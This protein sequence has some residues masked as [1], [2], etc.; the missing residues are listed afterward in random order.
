MSTA[1]DSPTSRMDDQSN[2]SPNISSPAS[3]HSGYKDVVAALIACIGALSLGL[4]LGY[5]NPALQDA[6]LLSVLGDAES[7]TWF[8]S[9][10]AI[11]AIFGGPCAGFLVAKCGRK[12]TLMLSVLPMGLG[13]FMIICG[14]HFVLFYF[15]RVASGFAMGMAS[16]VVPL[17]TAEVASTSR[18]GLL[19]AC[20]Q[21]FS[22]TGIL[23]VYSLGIPLGF[24]WLAVACLGVSTLHIVLLLLIPESPHWFAA[25]KKRP[26]ALEALAWLTGRDT[27]DLAEEY[28]EM[29]RCLGVAQKTGGGGGL[30]LRDFALPEIYRPMLISFGM[31]AYQQMS[32]INP[33]IFYSSE[34][35]ESAGFDDPKLPTITIGAVLVVATVVSC[36]LMDR[37]GR[38]LLLLAA[39][40]PMTLSLAALGTCFYLTSSGPVNGLNWLSLTSVLVFVVCFSLGVGP[41]S[42]LIVSELIPTRGRSII[43]GMATCIV[44]LL[45]FLATKEYGRMRRLMNDYG[46]FWFFAGCSLLGCAFVWFFVPETK[47]RTLEQ[48]QEIF[49]GGSRADPDIDLKDVSK[50]LLNVKLGSEEKTPSPVTVVLNQ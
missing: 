41:I 20:F 46:A 32:G 4:V 3:R 2:V 49:G 10:V 27:A 48:I 36:V 23:V 11:G 40:V 34:I 24:R 6:E 45:M 15:G 19:G 37:A 9:L 16:V 38:R 47:G 39:G 18:R 26:E 14:S 28:I 43:N 35:F 31:M 17:Y 8:G 29:E 50:D 30:S 44:W 13:W 42:W 25:Q 5:T 22:S 21:L 12:T 7:Q 1:D 33:V